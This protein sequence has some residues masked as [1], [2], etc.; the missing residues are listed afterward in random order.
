MVAL[1]SVLFAAPPAFAV[2]DMT[3]VMPDGVLPPALFSNGMV[4]QRDASVPV[5]GRAA[6]G[7][8]VTVSFNGQTKGTSAAPDGKWRVD[9]DPMP[10]GGP[11][12]MTIAGENTITITDV[13]VGEVWVCAGQ[14]NMTRKRVRRTTL[15]TTPT[16]RTL[17]RKNW[18]DQPGI[19]PYTFAKIVQEGLVGVPIGILNLASGGSD[20]FL[21]LGDTAV[22]DPDPEVA[23]YLIGAWG[24]VYRK[25]VKPLQPYRIRGVLWWQGEADVRTPNSHR[26]LYKVILRSWRDEWG[27][28]NFPWI[29]MI[30]PTGRGLREGQLPA[31]LP[32]NASATDSAAFIRQTYI[33]GLAEFPNSSV[34]SS[35]ELEGG[36]HPKDT[37]TYSERMAL[38]ALALVY[39]DSFVYSGPIFSSL[40]VEGSSL[41]VHFRA[42]T[43][44]GL[45]ARGGGA[46][47]GFAVSADGVT[48]HWADA[49]IDG[50]DVVVSSAAVP[51]PV[52]ARYAWGNRPTWANLVNVAG[53]AA[54][55][56]SSEVTPGEYGP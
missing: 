37:Y 24:T 40:D 12:T 7:E 25:F 8:S 33:R 43:A 52:Y 55:A 36:I 35:L 13:L 16:I 34:V 45:E 42:N 1:L 4:L 56:F 46:L 53:F 11:F 38:Q 41:R 29:S 27:I 51:S 18:T 44:V 22:T 10:A 31:L 14:S 28:G 21:W 50:D 30:V 6:A 48:W 20:A 5:F 47:Q 9:L 32:A 19:N 15:A 23:P 26:T 39:G 2:I 3:P 17:V 54:A 49:T